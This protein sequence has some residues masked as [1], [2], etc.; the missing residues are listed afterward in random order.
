MIKAVIIDDEKD[1]R[2]GLKALLT[3]FCSDVKVIAEAATAI[4]G[5]KCINTFKPQLV[6]L[7]IQMPGGTGF[8]LL[9]S[10]PEKN[11]KIIFT[12]AYDKH[13]LKA[14]KNNPVD[15]LLKPIDPDE[16]TEA[17]ERYKNLFIEKLPP[18]NNNSRKK[19]KVRLSASNNILL[20]DVDDI[21]NI[22]ADGRY[23]KVYLLNGS[24]HMITK[25]IGEFEEELESYDT[26]FRIHRSSLINLKHV[27]QIIRKDGGY[28]ELSNGKQIEISKRKK[29]EFFQKINIT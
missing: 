27:K 2:I 19:P 13:A 18:E 22:E 9:E 10:I 28:V 15:Y 4:E 26:F 3:E 5:I 25:N 7:D 11:F 1:A 14:I 29:T 6:F 8:D 16:L 12:T 20:V 17:V 21:V 23:S 24:T